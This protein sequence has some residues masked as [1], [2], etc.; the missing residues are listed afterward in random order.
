MLDAQGTPDILVLFARPTRHPSH[1]T[2][3][4]RATPP[5]DGALQPSAGIAE[6]RAGV[7]SSARL[8]DTAFIHYAM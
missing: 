6:L 4:P 7:P 5:R 1:V 2:R 3:K 8:K